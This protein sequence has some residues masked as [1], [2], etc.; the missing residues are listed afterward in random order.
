MAVEP[1]DFR[2]KF[3]PYRKVITGAN[4]LRGV[5]YL[6]HKLMSY[7]L[8]MPDALGYIP[9][10]DNDYPRCRLAKYIW[11]DEAN[12]LSKPLPTAAE[13]RSML[14]DPT[15]PDINTDELKAIHPKGYR[16]LWQRMVGQSDLD[17]N[18]TLKCYISRLF[19][20]RKFET[21]IGITFE[22]WV[23]VNLETNTR[24]SAYQRSL[25]IEQCLHEALDGVNIDGVGT[26]SFAR[27]ENTYNGSEYLWDST[28]SVGRL[29]NCSMLW[30]EGGRED[31]LPYTT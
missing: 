17:A 22:I 4:E 1:V 25:D 21:T 23:N 29:V 13:K 28:T 6:P 27:A 3:Y 5:E 8:D 26:I 14:F 7:L 11:Y 20:A 31:I 16:Y 12:P 10:D 2:S 30:A 24:T 19:E 9:P 15:R 18:I